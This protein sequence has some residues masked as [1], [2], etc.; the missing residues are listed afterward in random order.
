M[1]LL[2]LLTQKDVIYLSLIIL[3][4]LGFFLFLALSVPKDRADDDQAR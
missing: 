3:P 2:E 1:D 4:A